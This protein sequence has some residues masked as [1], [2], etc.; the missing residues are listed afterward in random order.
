MNSDIEV[1]VR[2]REGE[3]RKEQAGRG[4]DG[5]LLVA[6]VGEA[7]LTRGRLVVDMGE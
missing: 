7:G 3:G 1:L 6:L 2:E 4:W 5:E